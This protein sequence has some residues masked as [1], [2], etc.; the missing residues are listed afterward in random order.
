MAKLRGQVQRREPA[1]PDGGRDAACALRLRTPPIRRSGNGAPAAVLGVQVRVGAECGSGAG[2]GSTHGLKLAPLSL[3]APSVVILATPDFGPQPEPP[4]FHC[5]GLG[6]AFKNLVM[7]P[8]RPAHRGPRGRA[9]A[10]GGPPG[11][12][13][14][15][16]PAS[17][18]PACFLPMTR[19][20]AAAAYKRAE[21]ARC[22]AART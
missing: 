11:P 12:V 20:P 9:A 2:A 13:R 8:G 18:P 7:P 17:P 3:W 22:A 10:G 16:L 5:I 6:C 21:R 4:P 1:R 19:P 15:L 14:A